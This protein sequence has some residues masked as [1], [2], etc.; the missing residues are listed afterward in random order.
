MAK[1]GIN[2]SITEFNNSLVHL[3]NSSNV[4]PAAILSCLRCAELQLETVNQKYIREESMAYAKESVE[5]E[6][7]ESQEVA[8]NGKC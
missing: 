1:K 3:I 6:K 5:K 7:K 4:P 2:T 8:E